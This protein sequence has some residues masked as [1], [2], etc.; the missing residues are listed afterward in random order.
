MAH[1][2]SVR[3]SGTIV[4]GLCLCNS[5]IMRLKPATDDANNDGNYAPQQQQQQ[6]HDEEYVDIYLPPKTLYVLRGMAR[7]QYSHE[8]L[9]CGSIF[10]LR[11]F[12]SE[13]AEQK[14]EV[15]RDHR[16]SVIFRDAKQE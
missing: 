12:N 11:G 9:P 14:I 6:Q 4:S 8:L 3:F 10:E 5:A 15:K 7:F 16:I 2:D 1:V 13:D